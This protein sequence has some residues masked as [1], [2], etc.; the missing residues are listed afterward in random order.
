MAPAITKCRRL[1]V[2]Q[3]A[4]KVKIC[5]YLL[6]MTWPSEPL[7]LAGSG[8]FGSLGRARAE[9]DANLVMLSPTG[10]SNLD[11]LQS[12]TAWSVRDGVSYSVL[13]SKYY[14]GRMETGV[15]FATG[16]PLAAD[17]ALCSWK[18]TSKTAGPLKTPGHGNPM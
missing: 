18:R 15:G 5:I 8:V 2:T 11:A 4:G 16:L 13:R 12:Q 17:K 9:S 3:L 10:A 6:K 14:T 1:L 7:S